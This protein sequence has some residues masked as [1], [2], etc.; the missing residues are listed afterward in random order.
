MPL[1]SIILFSLAGLIAYFFL[2]G[3]IW[4]AG[5]APTSE[6]EIA[7]VA[8]LLNLKKGETFYDLGSGYGRMIIAIAERYGVNCVG[9]EIDPLKC[10]WT[11]LAIRRKKLQGSVKVINSNFLKVN[12]EEAAHVFLFLSN[13]AG[14]MERLRKKLFSEMKPGTVI[15][16]YMHRFKNWPP[17][18]QEGKLFVYL[19]P[20]EK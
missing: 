17:E 6:K 11:N 15:V 13:A 8:R 2:S 16:S 7:N 14:I 1:P 20:S 5:Y 12:L 9:V 10:W 3:F 18:K 4:G 19:I